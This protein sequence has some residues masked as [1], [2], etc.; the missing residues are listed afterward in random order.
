MVRKQGYVG[1]HTHLA[2]S[3][4][5]SLGEGRCY[6]TNCRLYSIP[7]H[8]EILD[9]DGQVTSEVV[10]G[11]SQK[12]EVPMV[13]SMNAVFQRIRRWLND[14]HLFLVILLAGIHIVLAYIH[15]RDSGR[16]DKCAR[17]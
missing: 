17:L 5:G 3:R 10:Y 2:L 14:H 6:F 16:A 7:E 15:P 4:C 13:K 8:S 11:P 9:Q 1:R 12:C